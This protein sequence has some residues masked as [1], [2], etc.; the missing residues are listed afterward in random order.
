MRVIRKYK[1]KLDGEEYEFT[2]YEKMHGFLGTKSEI[3]VDVFDGDSY[4]AVIVI[5]TPKE[6]KEFDRQKDVAFMKNIGARKWHQ[7]QMKNGNFVWIHE[8]VKAG[9][10]HRDKAAHLVWMKMTDIEKLDVRQDAMIIR[11][12]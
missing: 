1:V 12:A 10:K 6:K 2:V 7:D 11:A 8:G 3:L 4:S 9:E 5:L